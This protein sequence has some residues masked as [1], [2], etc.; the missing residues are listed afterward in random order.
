LRELQLQGDGDESP[1]PKLLF[2]ALRDNKSLRKL[3]LEDFFI[4]DDDVDELIDSLKVNET[5]Q[6][7]V[8]LPECDRVED[9]REALKKNL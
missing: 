6:E 4:E 8:F 9:V 3:E 2:Q 7:I 5:L 1:V